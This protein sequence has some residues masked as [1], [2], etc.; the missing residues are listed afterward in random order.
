MTF[1]IVARCP[2]TGH[3]GVGIA[4]AVPSVGSVCY[5]G[6]GNAGVV[7]TQ[8]WV[9]P[10]WAIDG[11]QLLSNNLTASEVLEQ[12]SKADPR[13]NLRQAAI[14][15]A[16]GEVAVHTGADCTEVSG[17][18]TAQGVS[19]QG[20]MLA[21]KQVL[22][23]MLKAYLSSAQDNFQTSL[24]SALTAAQAMGGDKRGKQSAALAIYST[25][26]YPLLDL[27]VDDHLEPLRELARLLDLARTQILPYSSIMSTRT[28]P[29]GRRDEDI[30]R[31]LATPPSER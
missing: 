20:N 30:E 26:E 13:T 22:P 19:V 8:S 15:D 27:R 5:Q 21:N 12:L 16:Q 24:L 28:M 1:S 10:Y 4:S 18:L 11:V 23:A 25:E 7:V 6:S 14:V 31:M 17:H 2:K 29:Q 9:N 3:F